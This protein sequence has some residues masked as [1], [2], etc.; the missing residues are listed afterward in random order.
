[1]SVLFLGGLSVSY[2]PRRTKAKYFGGSKDRQLPSTRRL[3]TG[4]AEQATIG[5]GNPSP[6]EPNVPQ[7][8]SHECVPISY[9]LIRKNLRLT[10]PSFE[11]FCERKKIR[12]SSCV[13]FDSF[14]G[15]VESPS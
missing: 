1:M 5:T 13:L 8:T 9:Y 11:S 14:V 2:G 6:Y 12:R 4:A 10:R 7:D 15:A 3:V